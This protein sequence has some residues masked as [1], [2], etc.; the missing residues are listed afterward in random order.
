M[1]TTPFVSRLVA[2][3]LL[4]TVLAAVYLHIV[5]PTIAAYVAVEDRLVESRSLIEHFDRLAVRG[6]VY[7]SR[8]AELENEERAKGYYLAGDTDALAAASLQ[9]RLGQVI[10][11]NAGVLRSLQ[12]LSGTDESGFRRIAVRVSIA[13]TTENLVRTLR[14]I[15]GG[16][17]ILFIDN[18]E[19]RS[20]ASLGGASADAAGGGG[21]PVLAV[22]FDVYGYLPQETR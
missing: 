4:L 16:L 10:D 6:P 1:L 12:P 18:L 17:P 20:D 21:E 22:G 8:L 15:E 14:D 13:A 7:A 3:M 2:V 5:E 11:T 9:D 19:I